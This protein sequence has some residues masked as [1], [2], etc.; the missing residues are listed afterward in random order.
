[1][2]NPGSPPA[3]GGFRPAAI[4]LP[5]TLTSNANELGVTR[6]ADKDCSKFWIEGQRIVGRIP[7]GVALR[8]RNSLMV[9]VAVQR[10]ANGRHRGRLTRH[11]FDYV[12]SDTSS[13]T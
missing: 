12:N 10:I 6:L 2:N 11:I 3:L 8:I 4:A 5:L 13:T 9:W 1:M 7:D